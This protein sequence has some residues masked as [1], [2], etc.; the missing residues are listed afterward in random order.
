MQNSTFIF[1]FYFAQKSILSHF[2][3]TFLITFLFKKI[4][5]EKEQFKNSD[6]VQ[7]QIDDTGDDGDDDVIF[8]DKACGSVSCVLSFLCAKSN[9]YI[10]VIYGHWS[11]TK[12]VKKF[13]F[14]PPSS[15]V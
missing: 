7:V 12:L 6:A 15:Q 13:D 2:R 8:S 1:R 11:N 4:K 9:F 5:R 14:Y 10:F 3:L